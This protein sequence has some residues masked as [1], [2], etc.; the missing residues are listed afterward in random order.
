MDYSQ[1]IIQSK[2]LE[3]ERER[4]RDEF[5]RQDNYKVRKTYFF[6]D[7]TTSLGMDLSPE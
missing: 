3:R 2:L 4:E 5:G 6:I 7:V 1:L